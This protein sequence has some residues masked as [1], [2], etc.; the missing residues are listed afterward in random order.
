MRWEKLW[1]DL[2]AQADAWDRE[3]FDAEVDD[4]ERVEA[5][6]I[7]LMDR[8][9]ACSGHRLQVQVRGGRRWDG[10]LAGHGSDWVALEADPSSGASQVVIPEAAVLAVRGLSGRAVPAGAVG[11]VAGRVS[12]AMVL[13]RAAQGAQQVC[14]H[15]DDGRVL[16][17]DVGRVGRDYLDVVDDTGTTWS[18]AASAIVGVTAG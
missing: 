17:G 4:R 18:V 14:L 12:L 15:L 2:V 8:V 16:R 11:P 7:T 6:A 10:T 9:R 5:A 3:D 13:R 1:A